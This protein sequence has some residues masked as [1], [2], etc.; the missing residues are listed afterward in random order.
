MPEKLRDGG[1]TLRA[2]HQDRFADDF[3]ATMKQAAEQAVPAAADVFSGQPVPHDCRGRPENPHRHATTPRPSISG[4]PASGNCGTCFL[5]IVQ[6]A[7]AST[8]VTAADKQVL[9]R[10]KLASPFLGS[11]AVD[12]DGHATDKALDGL[13]TMVA[14]EEKRIRRENPVARTTDLLECRVRRPGAL[15][16]RSAV[17]SV[18]RPAFCPD[19]TATSFSRIRLAG[20]G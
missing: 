19:C 5:P 15:E 8:G 10:A 14:A 16:G 2:L 18:S 11:T 3:I 6:K 17:A 4:S 9:D 13:F 12:M 20:L 1:E 7:T